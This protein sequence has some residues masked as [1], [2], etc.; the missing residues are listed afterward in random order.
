MSRIKFLA[1]TGACAA[2]LWLPSADQASA[3]Q[4][5]QKTQDIDVVICLDISGSMGGLVEQAK[6]KLWDIVNELAKA[7]PTPNLRVALYSYGGTTEGYDPKKG[8]VRK[9][10]DLTNDLDA[11]YKK[12]YELTITGGDEYVA[13]VTSDAVREQKWSEQKNALK[14]IFVAGNEPADQ[15]KQVTMKQ[16]ADAAKAKGIIIN[17]IYCGGDKDGD[18]VSWRE[19]TKMTG[20]SLAFINHNQKVVI[21]TPQDKELAALADKLNAT[22][23]AYGKGGEAKAENQKL[24][25][26]NSANQG[27]GVIASRVTYQNSAA[28]NCSAWCLVDRCKHDPKFDITKLKDEELP[29]FMKKMTP[30][31]RVKYVKD[32]TA[33]REGLQKEITALSQKRDAYI[34][35]EIKRNPNPAQAA[36]DAALR[37]TLRVQAKERGI[38]IPK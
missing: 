29:D 1:I 31:E 13:R 35:E 30:D 18:A 33:K 12:L 32:M 11:L 5:E 14:L 38:E 22:Y 7:K 25:S 19:F 34:R 16:A 9:E 15:D 24:Q 3:Q 26:A 10:I 2:C 28:Y 23:I 4:A 6:N 36:F 8:W 27:G 21:N 17:P 37:E 20:G